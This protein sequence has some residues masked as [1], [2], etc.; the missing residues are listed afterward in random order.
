MCDFDPCSVRDK[1]YYPRRL[2]SGTPSEEARIAGCAFTM[3]L[4]PTQL[5]RQP[6]WTMTWMQQLRN[7][8]ERFVPLH[9]CTRM[10]KEY[11]W[12]AD[13]RG[14]G[15]MGQRS[16]VVANTQPRSSI[17]VRQLRCRLAELLCRCAIASAIT[18]LGASLH[19]LSSSTLTKCNTEVY[20]GFV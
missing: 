7:V 14:Y 5:A 8:Q 1:V 2:L 10:R 3:G 18:H 4:S 13:M 16:V 17:L 15:R 9:D 20:D 12:E 6:R 19:S 11:E